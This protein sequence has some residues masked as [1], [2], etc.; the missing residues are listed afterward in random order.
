MLAVQAGV[1]ILVFLCLPCFA[2]IRIF[3]SPNGGA[4][5][6]IAMQID[7]AKN[8][9]DIAIYSLTSEPI[10]EAIIRAKERQIKIRILMDKQQVGGRNSKY[11]YFLDN[12]IDVIRDIHTGLMHNKI[13]VIDGKILFTGSFNW[14]RSAEVRNEEN[15]LEFIDEAEIIEIYQERLNYLW[16][17]NG[18]K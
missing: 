16:E 2:E 7:K 6:E 15:L 9:I 18:G 12:E 13:A 8:H 10:A 4:T 14:T 3:F 11:Q 17:F 1:T 5:K